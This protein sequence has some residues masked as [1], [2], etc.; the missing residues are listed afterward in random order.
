M[1]DQLQQQFVNETL[2]VMKKLNDKY[3]EFFH[4]QILTIVPI[5]TEHCNE[6]KENGAQCKRLVLG[7]HEDVSEGQ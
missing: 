7:V 5:D 6:C 4:F 2:D 3:K 1:N